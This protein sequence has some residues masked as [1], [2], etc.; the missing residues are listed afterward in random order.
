MDP[1]TG[2]AVARDVGS[3]T[4]SY[5]VPGILRTYKEVRLQDTCGSWPE[6][7]NFGMKLSAFHTE[8]FPFL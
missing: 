6:R 2:V 3:V 8:W 4:I 1:K 5:E 7:L